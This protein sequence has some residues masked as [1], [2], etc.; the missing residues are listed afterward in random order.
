MEAV[1]LHR[2]P[3]ILMTG[4]WPLSRRAGWLRARSQEQSGPLKGSAE[5]PTAG[6]TPRSW[7]RWAWA[8]FPGLRRNIKG[9][10]AVCHPGLD[11]WDRPQRP[12]TGQSHSRLQSQSEE[13]TDGVIYPQN[14]PTAWVLRAIL[15]MAFPCLHCHIQFLI[16]SF[17]HSFLHSFIHFFAYSFIRSFLHSLISS[18]IHF[19]THSFLHSFIH[20]FTHSFLHS[21]IHFF[22]Y[23]F[24]S[25][26]IH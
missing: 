6:L 18:L 25:S 22:T 2:Q 7:S 14:P 4:M 8:A 19:F 15:F 9:L 26:L 5:A 20:F 1:Q 21:F 10:V 17:I 12:E 23:S 13:E 16:H 24:V 11:V 3:A